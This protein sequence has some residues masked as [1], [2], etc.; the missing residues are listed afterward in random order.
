MCLHV[1]RAGLDVRDWRDVTEV[2]DSLPCYVLQ[3]NPIIICN[4][5]DTE[6]LEYACNALEV[7]LVVDCLQ[8]IL[9][10]IPMQLLSM[11]IATKLGWDVSKRATCVLFNPHTRAGPVLVQRRGGLVV[12]ATTL[13]QHRTEHFCCHSPV[14][15]SADACLWSSRVRFSLPGARK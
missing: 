13:N 14:L 5:G 1:C 11:H 2:A 15:L 3:G 6:T 8:G 7:P 4:T 9:T 12:S 10:V